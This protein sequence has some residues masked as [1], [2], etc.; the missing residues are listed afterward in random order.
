[1]NRASRLLCLLV[2]LLSFNGCAKSLP[3]H[4]T[5]LHGKA[6]QLGL[7]RLDGTL[8]HYDE[9]KGKV[10]VLFFGY[11]HC[12]DVCPTTLLHLAHALHDLP[13][14]QASQVAGIFVSVDPER[15]TIAIAQRYA[16]LF[17][18]HFIALG[19]TPSEVKAGEQ[20]YHV[21]AQRLPARSGS[22]DYFMA[23]SSVLIVIDGAGNYREIL[24]WD[25]SSDILRKDLALL[26]S[27]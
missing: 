25:T 8:F 26:T 13:Q 7:K 27:S 1:M 2:S 22:H 3:L 5:V 21:W 10:A 14:D 12:P 23:H 24:S 6:P 18:P 17:D 19:G 15:D 4:G 9:L 20:A 11:T 16:Q